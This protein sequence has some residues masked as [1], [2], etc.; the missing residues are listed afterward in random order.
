D[1]PIASGETW[2]VRA[3]SGAWEAA[4]GLDRP[5][6]LP[7]ARAFPSSGAAL[8][9]VL[10]VLLPLFALV[11][12]AAFGRR[13]ERLERFSLSPSALRWILLELWFIL[14]LNDLRRLPVFVG[15][16]AIAHLRYLQTIALQHRLP[17]PN[18]GWQTFQA[19]LYYLLSAPLWNLLS[20]LAGFR[21][22]RYWIRLLPIASGALQIEAAYRCAR[23]V[24]PARADLQRLVLLVAALMPMNVYLSQAAG[25]EP[26][27]GGLCAM[28]VALALAFRPGPRELRDLAVLGAVIGAALLAKASAFVLVPPAAALLA[29]RLRRRGLAGAAKGLGIA[30]AAAAAVCGWYY[31]GNILRY[32]TPIANMF[33]ASSSWWQEPGYRTAAQLTRFGTA[34]T[35]PVYAGVNGLWDSLYSTL[36]MDGYLSGVADPRIAPPW[37]YSFMFASGLLALVPTLAIAAGLARLRARPRDEKEE[38]LLFAGAVVALYAAAIVY[39]YL[40]LPVYSAGKASYMLGAT[41]CLAMLAA[42]GFDALNRN[43]AARAALYAALACWAVSVYAAY[44]VVAPFVP[45]AGG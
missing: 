22:A 17:P 4:R 37:N 40:L 12:A 24:F 35:R 31:A 32:G 41:P 25:N 45:V 11:F 15:F 3:A 13:R 23:T 30:A 44:F 2:E 19:P 16:D 26:L 43:R 7:V 29:W 42:S 34:L 33:A 36:W 1:L 10:P 5:W 14:G 27:A 28:A 20:A 39:V 38:A 8:A 18:E 21:L 9:D 6:D